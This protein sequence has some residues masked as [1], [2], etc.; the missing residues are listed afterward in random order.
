MQDQPGVEHKRNE[1]RMVMAGR[2]FVITVA[3]V[4]AVGIGFAMRRVRSA[5]IMIVTA[6]VGMKSQRGNIAAQMAVQTLRRRPGELERN[7]EHEEYGED[8]AH[9]EELYSTTRTSQTF[10]PCYLSST[11]TPANTARSV[12]ALV[13]LHGAPASS[14][15]RFE[16]V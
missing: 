6:I 4:A 10:S 5:I 16:I 15:T 8:T 11:V 14:T 2:M 9:G 12:E 1:D 7:E 3:A 13:N